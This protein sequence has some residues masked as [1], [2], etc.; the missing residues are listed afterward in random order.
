MDDADAADDDEADGTAKNDR[1][2]LEGD[3]KSWGFQLNRFGGE[4]PAALLNPPAP[5]ASKSRS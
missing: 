1:G 2:A 3:R 5:K 4:L